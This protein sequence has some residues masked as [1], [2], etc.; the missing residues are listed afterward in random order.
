MTYPD[1]ATR[2]NN[3][4]ASLLM[5]HMLIASRRVSLRPL[6]SAISATAP[7]ASTMAADAC[8]ETVECG[9][10]AAASLG[11]STRFAFL[12]FFS[13]RSTSTLSA[14]T[15]R[16]THTGLVGCSFSVLSRSSL[17]EGVVPCDNA[18]RFRCLPHLSPRFFLEMSSASASLLYQRSVQR[19]FSLTDYQAELFAARPWPRLL[20]EVRRG[21]TRRDKDWRP[22][23]TRLDALVHTVHAHLHYC[24]FMSAYWRWLQQLSLAAP[25][26]TRPKAGQ[27]TSDVTES[28]P[29]TT[30]PALHP[31]NIV[32]P[33]GEQLLPS[34]MVFSLPAN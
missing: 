33:E 30:G 27:Y 32:E 4:D 34:W 14:A 24:F 26:P 22:E 23:C 8:N 15:S 25:G 13:S 17:L 12:K 1:R 3:H 6:R 29:H 31:S 28:V 21:T 10:E 11:S 5:W 2:E 9:R 16:S 20:G 19:R 7:L 18:T